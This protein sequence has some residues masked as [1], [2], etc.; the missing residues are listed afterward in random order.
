MH[1][2]RRAVSID[3][4]RRPELCGKLFKTIT[5]AGMI[6][7]RFNIKL[8]LFLP[9]VFRAALKRSLGG[10]VEDNIKVWFIY[11]R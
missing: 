10:Q 9:L 1:L 5:N 6:L 7:A 4:L 2:F 8:R 11:R 3:K